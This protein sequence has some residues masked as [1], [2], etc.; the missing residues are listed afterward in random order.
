LPEADL[1]VALTL[2]DRTRLDDPAHGET[3]AVWSLTLKSE[4]ALDY[5][6][7]DLLLISPREGAP[8]R[9]YSIGSAAAADSRHIGLTVSLSTW[10]GED[11]QDYYGATSGLLC[12]TLRVGD[13]VAAWLRHH[14]TFNLPTNPNRPII[15]VA[16]GCGIAPF[17]G[18]L[19]EREAAGSLGASW[20][21][22]GNRH[23][24]G[25]F[26]HGPRLQTWLRDRVLER[27]DTAFSRDAEDRAQVQD[28][29]IQQAAEVWAWLTA[30]DAI[31]YVCGRLSTLGRGLDAALSEIAR[32]QG[33]LAPEAADALVAKW[34]AEGRIRRDLFD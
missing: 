15:M 25:D 28:R 10:V 17:I 27:L 31:L 26:L 24:D 22:F 18:F 2:L 5:R 11:G 21:I 14:P 30:R 9:C 4:T 33:H 19:A 23:R 34:R 16:T 12:R 1:P 29:L 13:R 6:A 32:L 7:G 3:N 20:L 8:E